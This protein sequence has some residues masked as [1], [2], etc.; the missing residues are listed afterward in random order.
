[1]VVVLGHVDHGKSKL[2]EA[3]RE[4]FR[5]TAKESG[6]ITQ[7][8]GAYVAEFEEKKIT[9]I[10]TPGHEAFSAMRSRGARVA[11]I[12]ILVIDSVEGVKSQ[13]KE[14]LKF[15]KKAEI[16]LIIVL[17]KTDLPNS[18]PEKVK[19]QLAEIDVLVESRGGKIPSVELSA[20]TGQGIKDLLDHIILIAEMEEL[21]ND[22]KS[23]PEGTVIE[24]YMDSKR[25]PVANV[26]LAKG[27]A[28][29]NNNIASRS[30]WGKI[31]SLTNSE[32]VLVKE[33]YPGQ[34]ATVL[35]F[36]KTPGVGERIRVYNSQEEAQGAVEKE[37]TIGPQVINIEK[38]KQVLNIVLKTDVQGSGE[39]IEGMLRNLPQDKVVLRVLKAEAGN[40]SVSDIKLAENGRAA[41][42]GFRVK[43]E[44]QTKKYAQQK[45]VAIKTFDV[46]YELIQEARREM[47]RVL[48][49]ETK[50]IDLGK[51][52]IL[53]FFKK[54]KDG[55]VIGG[56]VLE[57]EIEKGARAEVF[58]DEEN[59]GKGFVK[60]LQQDKNE[61]QKVKK[62]KECGLLF[63]GGPKIEEGDILKIFREEKKKEL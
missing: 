42:F 5:I 52:K 46:I 14:A 34:P 26:I 11:D 22:L 57:G 62:N 6:G 55:Q 19:G 44:N 63:G 27:I 4:D 61:A 29:E 35:G 9:F 30:A 37:E 32:G 53:A 3:V 41:I 59:I 23:S 8:I 51:I 36:E 54:S 56:K 49:P 50:R 20:K 43:M 15:V 33:I 2:L 28:K 38:G 48:E 40:I 24:S 7:H 18:N 17:N 31:K 13:T 1:M 21:K 39:A 45:E 12:A 10:D 25:G 16:P 60:D 58:R 47:I